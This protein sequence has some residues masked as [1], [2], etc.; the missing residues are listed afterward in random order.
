M[1]C[2]H[3][4]KKVGRES[5]SSH[6]RTFCCEHCFLMDRDEYA[7]QR[8]SYTLF[9]EVLVNALDLREHETGMHSKRVACHTLVM[10][11]NFTSD[12]ERLQQIY[13]GALLHDIGKL[14]IADAILLKPGALTEIEW[15]EMRTHPEK[16]F[17]LVSRIPEMVEASEII[18]SHEERY[19]GNGYPHRLRAEQI[20]LG[21]RLFMVIDTLDAMTSDRPYRRGDTFETARQEILQMSGSQFDPEAVEVFLAEESVLKEMVKNKCQREFPQQKEASARSS[22]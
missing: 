12:P 5:C 16:G 2:H 9:A 4:G 21:A 13:W 19:D 10:A 20:P 15:K 3:C 17:T 11:R 1:N 7:R 8:D 14:G 6:T 18:L 22:G